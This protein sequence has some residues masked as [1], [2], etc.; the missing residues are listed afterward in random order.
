MSWTTTARCGNPSGS[1]SGRPASMSCF[2]S[3]AAALLKHVPKT[4]C[5][6]TD[7]RM[8]DIDGMALLKRLKSDGSRLPVIMMTG[9]GDVPLAVEAMKLG[10]ADFIEKPFDDDVLLAAIRSALDRAA[11][12][13]ADSDCREFM[14][15]L[16]VLSRRE[17]QVFER[18]VQGESNKVI[19]RHLELSPRTIEIY[20]ANVMTKLKAAD[21]SELVRTAVKAGIA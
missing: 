12:L 19:A 15:R 1:C 4:G 13:P 6:L 2:T 16:A 5:I 18:L 3:S 11:S 17:R 21:F 7:I 9:H 20:R 10:A 14:E 8:A